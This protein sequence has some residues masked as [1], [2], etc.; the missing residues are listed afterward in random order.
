MGDIKRNISSVVGLYRDVT[1]IN[2]VYRGSNLVW[3][4]GVTPTQTLWYIDNT[5]IVLSDERAGQDVWI[6]DNTNIKYR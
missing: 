6:I 1:A 4:G 5:S 3:T 2:K